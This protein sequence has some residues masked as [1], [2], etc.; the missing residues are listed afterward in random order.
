[1]TTLLP[2]SPARRQLA[3]FE[4]GDCA[5]HGGFTAA[6]WTQQTADFAARQ[7]K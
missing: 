7:G 3:R 6:G 1:L 5:Q 2:V 4:P